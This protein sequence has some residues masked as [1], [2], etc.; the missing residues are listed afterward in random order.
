MAD[1]ITHREESASLSQRTEAEVRELMGM[2]DA[3]SFARRGHS[4]EFSLARLHD[5]CRSNRSSMLDMVRMR[6]KQWAQVSAGPDDWQNVFVGPIQELWPLSHAQEPSWSE[7]SQP[8]RRRRT[9]ARDLVAS[10]TRFNERWLRHLYQLNLDPINQMIREYNQFYIIEKECVLGSARLAAR[11][12]RPEVEVTV[13]F[14]VESHP[15]L[16]VPQL[17]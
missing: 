2:F 8:L 5:R 9:V 11:F 1:D 12:F 15:P 13:A 7:S 16:P 6:L 4:M 17:A 14:L 10:V 3:P